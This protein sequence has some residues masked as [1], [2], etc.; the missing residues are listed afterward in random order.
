MGLRKN[1]LSVFLLVFGVMF[2][3]IVLANQVNWNGGGDVTADGFGV[4][5]TNAKSQAQATMMAR[6]AAIVDAYRNLGE[7]A[8]GV[9][10]D[11]ETSVRDAMVESDVIRTKMSAVV[12]GAIIISEGSTSEGGY[13]VTMKIPLFGVNSVASAV[14]PQNTEI[15]PFAKPI[16]KVPTEL[17][18]TISTPRLQ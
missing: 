18:P 8:E 13:R 16:T 1:L 2:T 12:K 14:M 17:P 6:R 15:V 5:P 10:V 3:G 7:M 11:S 9:L 4:A